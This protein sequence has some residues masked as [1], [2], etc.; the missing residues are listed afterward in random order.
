MRIQ[1]ELNAEDTAIGAIVE[2]F[3]QVV[4]KT[5][6]ERLDKLRTELQEPVRPSS[7][8]QPPVIVPEGVELPAAERLKAADLR[9]A[10]LLGKIPK[11]AGLLIDVKT[12]AKLLNVSERIG[13]RLGAV[14]GCHVMLTACLRPDR[15]DGALLAKLF[16]FHADA[17]PHR[18]RPRLMGSH[19][20]RWA[21]KAIAEVGDRQSSA[22]SGAVWS[23]LETA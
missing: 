10:L 14:H 8:A 20:R 13:C 5:L 16:L 21:C 23:E 17:K 19:V 15:G 18:G 22:G 6:T 4:E 2:Q 3:R 7:P 1:L 12:T 11:D 9:T